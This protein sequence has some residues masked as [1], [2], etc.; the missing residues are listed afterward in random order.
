MNLQNSRRNFESRKHFSGLDTY[1]AGTFEFKYACQENEISGWGF[2]RGYIAR[3]L[4]DG[5]LRL[6]L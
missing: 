4:G 3:G 2:P 6:Q 5:T 1:K